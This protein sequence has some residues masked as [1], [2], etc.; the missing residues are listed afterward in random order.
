M[1]PAEG[2]LTFD[3]LLKKTDYVARMREML[4]IIEKGYECPVDV[5]FTTNI[6]PDGSY[7]IDVVQCR[8]LHVQTDC[9]A[10]ALPGEISSEDVL[11]RAGDAIIGRSRVCV[12]DRIIYVVPRVYGQLPLADRYTIARLVGRLC[13][14]ESAPAE[15]SRAT[16]R[17]ADPRSC[18]EEGDSE[19]TVL[20]LGPGRWGTSMPSLGVPVTFHEISNIAVLGEIVAMHDNLVPDVSLGTH[21]FNELVEADILYFARLSQSREQ[22]DQCRSFLNRRRTG[23][24]N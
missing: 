18:A 9:S 14:M 23:S 10:A 8:P 24:S 11:F 21:L 17:A 12:V 3:G 6:R 7:L 4:A 16:D 22:H 1:D 15:A 5:E 20:L 13:G 19:K 2:F